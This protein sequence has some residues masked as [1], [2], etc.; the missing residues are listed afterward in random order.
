M[1]N[2]YSKSGKQ[3]GVI[4]YE[5]GTDYIRV[6]FRQ[7]EEYTYSYNDAGKAT[8]EQMKLLALNSEGLSTFIAQVKPAFK[9]NNRRKFY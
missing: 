7:G 5:L 3:S 6:R 4:A 2:Y 9:K 1:Q 8:V